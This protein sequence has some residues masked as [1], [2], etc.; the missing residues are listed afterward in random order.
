MNDPIAI[1]SIAASCGLGS[2]LGQ[3]VRALRAGAI[4]VSQP[5]SLEQPPGTEAGAGEVPERTPDLLGADRAERLL[6]RTL[7]DL[8]SPE[9][10]N[11]IAAAPE[12]WGIVLGTTLAGM[13]HCGAGLRLD[14]AGAADAAAAALARSVASAVMAEAV[15]GT[16]VRGPTTTLSCACASALTAIAHGCALIEAGDADAVIAGGYD[17]ISE[18]SFA[19]FSALQLVSTGPVSPFAPDREGMKVGEGVALFVLRRRLPEGARSVATIIALGEA[20][21]AHHL[22][23]PHPEGAGAARALRATLADPRLPD[24]ILAHATGT[25]G[26]DAA[27]HAAY[28]LALGDRLPRVP[29]LALKGRTAHPLAAA[30]ALELAV[31]LACAEQGFV[32]S[33]AGRGRD[34]TAFPDLALIEGEIRPES[35]KDI[36]ALAAGFGGANAAVRVRRGGDAPMG[37]GVRAAGDRLN[38]PGGSAVLQG[39]GAVSRRGVGIE[40]VLARDPIDATD[41][42]ERH[43]APL[44]DRARTRRLALLPR[45]MLAAVRDLASSCGMDEAALQETPVVAA[46]WCG[47]TEFTERYYRELIAE[48]IQLANPMLFA[49]S[50]PNVG[51]AHVSLG[52]GIRAPCTSVVGRRTAALE[53]LSLARARIATGDWCRAIVVAAEEAHPLVDRVL[54]HCTGVPIHLESAAIA[55]LVARPAPG[56]AG[57][58]LAD[59]VGRTSPASPAE[60][61]KLALQASGADA[62]RVTSSSR[63]D[64]PLA[65]SCSTIE[66]PEMGSATPLAVLGAR[67]ARA[68]GPWIG[69]ACDPHGAA[70]T[71][72]IA[73]DPA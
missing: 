59:A 67:A 72:R 55:C 2:D 70:W 8:L 31:S 3:I 63:F 9:D 6:V 71:A 33:S 36:V 53:A 17:P 52:F 15:R 46:S 39:F 21:D 32:P 62:P 30:G 69:A 18:F 51:S 38:L 40:Q 10:R 19:G 47:A 57:Y 1:T 14:A 60:A 56:V 42:I 11:A 37:G 24:L 29:V 65:A 16:G 28:K 27:E 26:N 25:P 49:E 23:Q 45:L 61:A 13:R 50:V 48:G 73:P 64:A 35:P 41:D 4:G 5:A 66:L 22:T 34:T 68:G 43:I 7:D 58:R 20:C 44:L 54:A 12:R